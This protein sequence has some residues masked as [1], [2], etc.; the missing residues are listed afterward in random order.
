MTEVN[1]PDED[2]VL[3]YRYCYYCKGVSL[4]P[5]HVYD[6]LEKEAREVAEL[7]SP[8]HLP[9][10]DLPDHYRPSIR[11]LATYLLMRIYEKQQGII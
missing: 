1:P 3:A 7:D 5:D 4:V 8:L 10:S 6:R 9:G 11:A 2:L